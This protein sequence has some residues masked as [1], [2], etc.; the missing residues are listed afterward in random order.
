M[1]RLLVAS[2]LLSGSVAAADWPQI[3]GPT[4]DGHSP[5][6]K[7]N[8]DWT[9]KPP[10]VAWTKDIGHGWAGVVVAG[11]TAFLFHRVE[12]EEVLQALDAATGK[13]K[14]KFAYPAKY[15]DDF[16]FDDGPRA[17]PTVAEGVAYL[18]G[19]N[20]D[21]HAVDTTKGEKK[22]H[23]NVL[24][25]YAAGK[26]Y[27]GVAASPV[28]ADDKVIVNVGGK[29]ASLVAFDT[30]SGKELWKVADDEAGYSSPRVAEFGGKNV[31]VAFT[32]RGL[33]GVQLADGKKLF[34]M[35]WRSRLDASVNA[36]VPL[37]LDGHIFLTAAYGT[38]AILL[39]CDGASI[40]EVWA[41]DKS[42]SCQYSTPVR[43]GD[44][45][46][47]TD[48][49]ADF[50]T[51][52]LRCV[53]WK[54]GEVVWSQE[55]FGCASVLAVDGKLL[56]VTEGGEVV[57][58]EANRQKFVELGRKAVLDGKVRAVP[59]LADGRLYMR[60]ETKLVCVTLK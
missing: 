47:G 26:G 18:L 43:V 45:L 60:D 51:G 21:L 38:G 58:F 37:I 23:R 12:N 41:N 25:D 27:F 32:R 8:W 15:Q 1:L 40:E 54:T 9:A 3:L 46:Y 31:V 48:G 14:W 19:A 56:A 5:E 10:A 4:R 22:W 20:G 52:R 11:G 42:L 16:G 36:A 44:Y 35:K 50:N 39:K 24:K 55:R 34:E 53:S 33:L 6:T 57:A 30:A 59:A 29:G 2:L 13:P 28:V 17:T 49:R 7:L